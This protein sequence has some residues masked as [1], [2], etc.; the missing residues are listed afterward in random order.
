ME[1][2]ILQHVPAA[3]WNKLRSIEQTE[4]ESLTNILGAMQAAG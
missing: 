1:E 2:A 4:Q 3:E